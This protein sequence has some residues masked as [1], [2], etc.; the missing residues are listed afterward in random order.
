MLNNKN[1]REL[2]WKE[3]HAADN[4]PCQEI[5]SM[6]RKDLV[7]SWIEYYGHPPPA[8]ISRRLLVH[9]TVYAAQA[10]T[11]G[12]LGHDTRRKIRL[13]AKRSANIR[14]AGSS[15][16]KSRLP[17]GT[18]LVREWQGIVHAVDVLD[19]GFLY[20]DTIYG[21]LSEVARV[22]TGARWSGPRFF[23]TRQ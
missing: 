1:V 19:T 3:A 23:G 5:A 16:K 20:K 12:E 18:R 10:A 9:A 13:I 22:I 2:N 14:S 15:A 17:A 6:S 21:S 7:E 8:G 4:G 11:H